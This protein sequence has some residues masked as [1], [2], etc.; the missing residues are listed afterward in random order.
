M[1]SLPRNPAPKINADSPQI[2]PET[3]EF[4]GVEFDKEW[5]L[6][7]ETI[8]WIFPARRHRFGLE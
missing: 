7:F 4:G 2:L 1:F 5:L 3:E 8:P 6:L